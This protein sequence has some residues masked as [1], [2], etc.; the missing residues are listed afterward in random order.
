MRRDLRRRRVMEQLFGSLRE[1]FTMLKWDIAAD[2]KDLKKEV[3]DLGQA[4]RL[5]A[6]RL[7]MQATERQVAELR[8][9][10]GTLTCREKTIRQQFERFYA[11]IYSAEGV[12]QSEVEDYLDSV[13]VAR[14]PP[15]G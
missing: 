14:L 10:H 15:G 9:P 5:L 3:I 2:I 8:L 7:C 13:P 11:D 6:H 12:D 4:G 1:D